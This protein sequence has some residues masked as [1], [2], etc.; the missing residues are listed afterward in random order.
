MGN[1]VDIRAITRKIPLTRKQKMGSGELSTYTENVFVRIETDDGLVGYGECGPWPIFAAEHP[2]GIVDSIENELAPLVIGMEPH[3]WR[4]LRFLWDRAFLGREYGKS[5]IEM[6]IFDLIGKQ[7]KLPLHDL[8]GGAVR[9]CIKLSYSVSAQNIKQELEYI[10]PLVEEKAYSILKVKLGILLPEADAERLLEIRKNFPYVEMRV[11]FNEQGTV[12]AISQL[13][14]VIKECNVTLIEQPFHA[15]DINSLYWLANRFDGVLMADESCRNNKDLVNI[16]QNH[17]FQAI[18]LKIHKL[19][20]ISK[21]LDLYTAASA[22]GLAGYCGGTSD[23]GLAT[24]ANIGLCLCIPHLIDGC[25]LYFPLEI[26]TEEVTDPP[27]LV[28]DGAIWPTNQPGIGV[29]LPDA[30]FA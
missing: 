17:L 29:N 19:G 14:P 10:G 27:I 22:H 8:L 16:T 24:Y 23:T 21:T 13:L 15:N 20:G 3:Q 4:R 26:L 9:E 1:I 25:D 28:R 2:T 30:W 6:A 12:H 7:A 11:D 5:A 18:S